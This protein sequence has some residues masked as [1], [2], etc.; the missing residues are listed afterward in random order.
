MKLRLSTMNLWNN[1]ALVR[2]ALLVFVTVSTMMVAIMVLMYGILF[3]ELKF[4]GTVDGGVLV[5]VI[6]VVG[7]TA[8]MRFLFGKAGAAIQGTDVTDD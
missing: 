3:G 8:V 6:I 5:G 4:S 7:V 2:N 1:T